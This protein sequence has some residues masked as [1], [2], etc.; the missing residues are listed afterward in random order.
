[1]I[2]I[3]NKK[4]RVNIYDDSMWFTTEYTPGF[5]VSIIKTLDEIQLMI[6]IS[7]GLRLWNHTENG[8]LIS[9]ELEQR[10]T[11][12]CDPIITPVINKPSISLGT[13]GYVT[14]LA[15]MKHKLAHDFKIHITAS[16]SIYDDLKSYDLIGMRK[17]ITPLVKNI[18]KELL[19]KYQVTP[20]AIK[21]ANKAYRDQLLNP[22]YPDDLP[23]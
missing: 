12:E 21:D 8:E 14:G 16:L 5:N 9:K 1:M 19:I 7:V 23:F 2:S 10:F 15:Q 17:S 20:K 4:T 3:S 11:A 22:V 13:N 6:N 18:E